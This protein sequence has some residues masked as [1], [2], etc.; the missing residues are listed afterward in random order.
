MNIEDSLDKQDVFYTLI[1]QDGKIQER[2]I[3]LP[4]LIDLDGIQAAV[5]NDILDNKI[6]GVSKVHI[7]DWEKYIQAGLFDYKEKYT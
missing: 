4:K 1:G 7:K 6:K 5:K 2:M 3:I